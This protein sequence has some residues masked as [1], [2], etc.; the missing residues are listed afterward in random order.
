[1]DY[2]PICIVLV[3]LLIFLLINSKEGF[4]PPGV[5]P[6][7]GNMYFYD[8]IFANDYSGRLPIGNRRFGQKLLILSYISLAEIRQKQLPEGTPIDYRYANFV[9]SDAEI[10]V[11]VYIDGDCVAQ[12]MIRT[13]DFGPADG[14]AKPLEFLRDKALAKAGKLDLLVPSKSIRVFTYV[15]RH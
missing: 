8:N 14:T 10:P 7:S 6:A 4:L 15:D 13:T 1:M 5:V 11:D 9:F 2:Q 3:I 12:E